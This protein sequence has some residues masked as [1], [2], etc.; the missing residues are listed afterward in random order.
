MKGKEDKERYK[1]LNAEFQR[2]TRRN[3]T[4][5]LNEQCIETEDNRIG[6][7]GS[8]QENQRYQ[9]N[10]SCKDGHNKEQKWYTP[11]RNRRY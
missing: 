1:H 5:F 7:L 4:A 8:L 9:E 11:N 6:R 10:I 2:R 3:K